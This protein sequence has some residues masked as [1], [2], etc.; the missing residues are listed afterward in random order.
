MTSLYD[1]KNRGRAHAVAG[2]MRRVAATLD[3]I[4]YGRRERDAV[5]SVWKMIVF[6]WFKRSDRF[7]ACV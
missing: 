2:R 3:C 5:R 6:P 7:Y 1:K 4:E